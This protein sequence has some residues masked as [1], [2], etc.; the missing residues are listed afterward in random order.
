MSRRPTI[1]D[2]EQKTSKVMCDCLTSERDDHETEIRSVMFINTT[3]KS[4]LAEMDI[5]CYDASDQRERT[6]VVTG[7]SNRCSKYKLCMVC[8]LHIRKRSA[9]ERNTVS[10]EKVDLC[11]F[12]EWK[13]LIERIARRPTQTKQM[14]NAVYADAPC[15]SDCASPQS[16]RA[17]A[18]RAADRD[19][20]IYNAVQLGREKHTQY[21]AARRPIIVEWERDARHSAGLSFGDSSLRYRALHFSK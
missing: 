2:L 4:E 10:R 11:N 16:G 21:L 8:V 9:Y 19:V 3:L 5:E 20:V 18:P 14:S 7:M 15:A 6:T 1:R 13:R 12:A 17:C